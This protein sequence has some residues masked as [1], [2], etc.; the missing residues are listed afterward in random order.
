MRNLEMLR[1][2]LSST[3]AGLP[4]QSLQTLADFAEFLRARSVESSRA[5]AGRRILTLGGSGRGTRPVTE[6]DIAEA[7]KQMWGDFG[8]REL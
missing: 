8:D 2:E 5:Q 1:A 3:I 7:R 4:P 6:Q